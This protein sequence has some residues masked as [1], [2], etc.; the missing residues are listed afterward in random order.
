MAAKKT[1]VCAFTG[2]TVKRPTAFRERVY[3]LCKQIPRGKVS[4]Y[5]AIADALGTCARAVGTA[6]RRNP[7][8]AVP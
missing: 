6:M 3:T 1:L 4:T 7:Y 2:A 8:R 5:G